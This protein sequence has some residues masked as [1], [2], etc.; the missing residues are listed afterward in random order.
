MKNQAAQ[1]LGKLG[2]QKTLEKY[3]KDQ[4]KEWG[5]IENP[6]SGTGYFENSVIP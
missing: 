5:K 4:M 1:E 6:A 2:G 3:G